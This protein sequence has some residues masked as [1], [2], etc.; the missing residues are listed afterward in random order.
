MAR[1]ISTVRELPFT[2]KMPSD[3]KPPLFNKK[4]NISEIT[5]GISVLSRS[6]TSS[7]DTPNVSIGCLGIDNAVVGLKA[8]LGTGLTTIFFISR[9]ITMTVSCRKKTWNTNFR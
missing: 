5:I 9:S 7:S 6:I 1:N 4:L 3:C 8:F 2:R